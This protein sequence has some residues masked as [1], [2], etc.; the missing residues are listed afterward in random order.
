MLNYSA[1][2]PEQRPWAAQ[3]S[4]KGLAWISGDWAPGFPVGALG[5]Q[6]V[7]TGHCPLAQPE[8][9]LPGGGVGV[10]LTVLRE[11]RWFSLLLPDCEYQ[12]WGG[13]PGR[14]RGPSRGSCQGG[15]GGS[16]A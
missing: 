16:G 11:P 2:A 15:D 1:L 6:G 13:S 9:G 7:V 14:W 5:D 3:T 4:R 8:P 12:L 10:C